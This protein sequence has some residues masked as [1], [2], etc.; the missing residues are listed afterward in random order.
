MF[1]FII[2][3][4]DDIENCL[5]ICRGVV[6]AENYEDAVKNIID[7]VGKENFVSIE[8]LYELDDILEDDDIVSDIIN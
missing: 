2:H 8:K 3:Y 5:A 1:R 4:F 7:Y 6:K